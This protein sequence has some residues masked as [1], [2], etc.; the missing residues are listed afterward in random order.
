MLGEDVMSRELDE[1][2]CVT[3]GWL[4][5]TDGGGRR[6]EKIYRRLYPLG[7]HSSAYPQL[8]CP[9]TPFPGRTLFFNLLPPTSYLYR[10]R[11]YIL[12]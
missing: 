9:L 3:D 1:R 8:P 4:A 5:V 2:L 7:I 10:R 6:L 12:T 11:L